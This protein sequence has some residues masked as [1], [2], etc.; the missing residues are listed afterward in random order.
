MRQHIY[1]LFALALVIVSCKSEK[2]EPSHSKIT[3]IEQGLVV[4]TTIIQDINDSG[5]IVLQ[6]IIMSK[7]EAKPSFKTGGVIAKTYVQEGQI[8]RKGQLLATLTMTEID[9]QVRQAEEGLAK[10]ERD[11][12]RAKNLFADSV[13]TLE[14][15]QNATTAFEV[16]KRTVEIARF[17]RQYSEMRSPI[18]GKVVK[19]IMRVGEI[20]GPGMPVY[21]IMGTGTQDWVVKAGLVDR[22]WARVSV[23][24]KVNINLDAFSGQNFQGVVTEKSQVSQSQSGTFDVEIKFTKQPS[25]LAAGLIAKISITPKR[26]SPYRVVPIECLVES[27]GSKARAFTIK[28]GKAKSVDLTIERILGDKVAI[29]DGL[30]DV[31]ELITVGAMYLEEGDLV[32]KQ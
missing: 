28:D 13:A 6:G 7:N 22:D 30:K 31:T 29:S 9:A 2:S 16:A 8:V 19:H 17:N 27:S 1:L 32:R 26:T 5:N 24:D 23:G 15:M 10:S 4:K 25:S 11:L 3:T 20:V 18:N 21:A 12:A 14:Q